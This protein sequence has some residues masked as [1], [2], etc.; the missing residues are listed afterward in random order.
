MR[1]VEWWEHDT[2][3]DGTKRHAAELVA[4]DVFEPVLR[5]RGN[6]SLA[7]VELYNDPKFRDETERI[8]RGAPA[9]RFIHARLPDVARQ[10]YRLEERVKT[11]EE[12]AR[13]D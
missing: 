7:A 10:L 5:S 9:G 4:F 2:F 8:F 3:S 12:G 11:L 1:Y 6:P 13:S